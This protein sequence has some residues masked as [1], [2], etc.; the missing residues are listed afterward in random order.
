MNS[1]CFFSAK[2]RTHGSIPHLQGDEGTHHRTEP[3]CCLAISRYSSASGFLHGTFF[4]NR[5]T[6]FS[7]RDVA[8]PLAFGKN[9]WLGLYLVY[10]FLSASIIWFIYMF[11]YVY[12]VLSGSTIWFN[13]LVE[14][15]R[16]NYRVR[17]SSKSPAFLSQ[18]LAQARF[19]K[20]RLRWTMEHLNLVTWLVV[21]TP[22][23]NI[24][25]LGCYSN[26]HGKS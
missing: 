8:R 25:Q 15:T 17:A 12:L 24:N 5:L 6:F 19:D 10:L 26:I 13:N 14:K 9:S 20:S 1:I 3:R 2:I 11:I 23:T 4:E 7:K 22:L 21:S 18:L 16:P